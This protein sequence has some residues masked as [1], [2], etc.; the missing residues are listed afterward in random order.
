MRRA[1]TKHGLQFLVAFLIPFIGKGH[2]DTFPAKNLPCLRH[3]NAR[4]CDLPS[5]IVHLTV[6]HQCGSNKM[7]MRFVEWKS[8]ISALEPFLSVSIG[9]FERRLARRP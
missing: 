9:T 6:F 8:G 4:N 7:L 5:F 2:V 3:S 1:A